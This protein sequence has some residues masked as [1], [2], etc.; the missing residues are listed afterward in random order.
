M[1]RR[2]AAARIGVSERTARDWDGGV[3][4]TRDARIYPDGRRVDYKSGV[5]THVDV[6]R[7]PSITALEAELHPRFLTLV[8]RE[9]IADLRREGSSFRAIGKALGRPASTVKREVDARAVDGVYRAHGAHRAWAASRARP[10]TA[11]LATAS[12]LRDF[13][14]DG[15]RRRWSPEQI[16]HALV[17]QFPDDESMRVST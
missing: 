9:T 6:L 13:V 7:S 11:K 8:E 4:K 1:S 2:D 15:L 5:T 16:C 12:R 3:R 14:A 10:K 17:E